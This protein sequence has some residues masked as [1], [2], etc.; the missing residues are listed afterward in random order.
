MIKVNLSDGHGSGNLVKVSPQG[1]ILT[2]QLKFSEGQFQ[3]MD[4][5]DTAFNFFKPRAGERFVITS[6]LINTNKDIGVNGAT[7]DIYEASSDSSTSID[8]QLL[9]II[10]LKNET[11]VATGAFVAV[12]E[13]KFLNGKT[14]DATVNVTLGGYY[15]DV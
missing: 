15:I 3:S 10:P 9:R 2:R 5:V 4:T 14:D 13:G 12:N 11:I 7:V 1:E 8:K 6:I